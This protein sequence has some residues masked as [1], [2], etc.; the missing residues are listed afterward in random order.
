MKNKFSFDHVIIVVENLNTAIEDFTAL[1][2]GVV[3][4]GVH[5]G[6][7]THNALIPFQDGTYIELLAPTSNSFRTMQPVKDGTPQMPYYLARMVED[8]EG[9]A[10]F[11]LWVY[12]IEQIVDD[13][14]VRGIAMSGPS[15]G[16]RQRHDGVDL[17]WKVA[18][19]DTPGLPFF[20]EDMT[21]RALRVPAPVQ[22]ANGVIGMGGVTI[23]TPDMRGRSALFHDL[24]GEEAI[25]TYDSHISDQPFD[26]FGVRLGTIVIVPDAE[27]HGLRPARLTLRARHLRGTRVLDESKSHGA[28]IVLIGE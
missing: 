10:G 7:S 17:L 5:T 16:G 21:N 23:A 26:L 6:N 15:E 22:H 20:I 24:L 18:I 2:F 25:T 19:P 1:G 9:L 12:G 3:A 8:G 14:A 28:K 4:G 13:A 27:V 11:A